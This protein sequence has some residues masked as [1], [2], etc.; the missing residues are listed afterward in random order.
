MALGTGG[1][2]G[3]GR[4]PVYRFGG[5]LVTGTPTHDRWVEFKPGYSCTRERGPDWHGHHGVEVRF[6]SRDR[7][8]GRV[9]QLLVMTGWAPGHL[10]E[11]W[12]KRRG[13]MAPVCS[14]DIHSP[15]PLYDGQR[16]LDFECEVLGG[17]CY[18][19]GSGL[20]GEKLFEL[21]RGPGGLDAMFEALEGWMA[22]APEE[23]S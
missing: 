13:L 7:A 9:G 20:F 23:G 6:Y 10:M 22:P 16:P 1:D 12:A 18:F 4:E 17:E 11:E 19:D 5:G 14:A 3:C 15:A 21:L 8:T 2:C